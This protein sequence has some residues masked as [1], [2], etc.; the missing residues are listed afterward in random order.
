MKDKTLSLKT[1]GL[2]WIPVINSAWKIVKVKNCFRISKSKAKNDN[3]VI[4]SLARDGIKVRDISTNEGQLAANY[5]DYNPVLPG[6]LL[7][8]PMDLYSGANC[9]MSEI[10]GV[11]SPAYSNLRAVVPLNSKFFDYYFKTQYWSMAMFAHGKG[12][13]FDNRWTLNADG[14][15]NYEIPF[16]PLETQDEIVGVLKQKLKTIDSLIQN[17][18]EQI[19]KLEEYKKA[20]I[21]KAVTKSL[22]PNIKTKDSG[23]E[24]IGKI[25]EDWKVV[26]LKYLFDFKKGLSITKAD[27]KSCGIKVISYGQIHS[28]ANYSTGVDESLYRF[29]SNEYLTTDSS[30]L[31]KKGDLIF[32]DTSEDLEGTGDFVRISNDELIFAGYHSIILRNIN[33]LDTEYLSYLFLSDEW[34]NQLRCGVYGVKLFSLTQRILNSC[35]ALLPP[36]DE[37]KRIVNF[38]NSRTI[39]IRKIIEI[40]KQKIKKMQEYKKSLIYEYVTGKKVV[41][42]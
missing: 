3:P 20:V 9:N 18:T 37:Q 33:N 32:A 4:L 1:T 6:D 23:V 2:S 14:L 29:V 31:V 34:R 19:E 10:S 17:E 13:S 26:S 12:V 41:E 24:W 11:I 40:K 39:S 15:L 38:L 7:L 27:L 30:S 21:T 36:E 28:K 5:S 25:P 35:S 42:A 16:P 22:N 8:N